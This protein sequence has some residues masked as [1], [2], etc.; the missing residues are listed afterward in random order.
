MVLIWGTTWAVIR[1]GLASFPPFAGVA[2]RFGIAA[3]ILLG[4]GR[5]WRVPN[6]RGPRLY[7]IWFVETVFSLC[8]PYGV[9]YWAEQW[10][11]SGLGS[12]LFAT[13]PLFVAVLAH[14]WLVSEP[15]RA[16]E[17][18]GI[19]VAVCGVG[20]IFSDDLTFAARPEVLIPAV[21]FL[22][23]PLAAAVA[24]VLIK[25]WGRGIHPLNVVTV[26][27][28]VTG[29]VMGALSLAVESDR[30][31]TF[32]LLGIGSVLYL[33]VLGS[34]LAFTLYYWVLDRVA[35]T[36]LSLL[37][38]GIPVVAVLV[39][40]LALGEPFSARIAFGAA[41]VLAGVGCASRAIPSVPRRDDCS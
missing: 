30:E 10:V 29:V 23:S 36:R 31:F 15:L 37:T 35:A 5:V 1:I 13:M 4:V 24:H 22:A 19:L 16:V 39:G 8:I 41:L 26:P 9:V 33:A 27:M 28:A 20:F 17:I 32:G 25:R 3:L 21:V 34:A 11:P 2:L 7:R 40:T 12:I 14:W 6:Q 38:L 18:A